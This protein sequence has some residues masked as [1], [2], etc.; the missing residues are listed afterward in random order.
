VNTPVSA[1]LKLPMAT[2][3]REERPRGANW[4]G[5]ILE[6]TEDEI[7]DDLKIANE[8]QSYLFVNTIINDKAQ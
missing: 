8:V 2:L 3:L 5:L 4:P 6:V 1:L 7:L